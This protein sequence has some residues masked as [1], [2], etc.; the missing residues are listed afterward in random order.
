M[1]RLI[2]CCFA[3]IGLLLMSPILLLFMVLVWLQDFHSPFY[4]AQRVGRNGKLFKMVKLRSMLV[5]SDKSGVD[6]T[7]VE[8][9]RI[10]AVGRIIRQ[11]K[12]DEFPELWNVFL[13]DMSL[14]GPRPNVQRDVAL[15]TE[16]EKRL[17]DVRPG[18]TDLSS[19]VFSDE[20]DILAGSN[21]PDLRYN[22]LIRPWKSRLGLFY[23]ENSS[24]LLDIALIILTVFTLFSREKA[25]YAI[26]ALLRK[27]EADELLIQVAAR[28]QALVPYPPPGA[29]SIVTSR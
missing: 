5:G 14:V 7:A 10:T 9:K 28:K 18:I 25:L 26:T 15:Y 12:L 8:D 22:Q 24:I 21:D 1:K 13:G 27:L 20:G 19:I 17:L 3:C 4:I 6:S 16:K 23:V 2:D 11:Y 29:E